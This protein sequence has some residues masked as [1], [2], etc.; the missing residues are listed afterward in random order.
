LADLIEAGGRVYAE[1]LFRAAAESGRVKQVDGDLSDFMESL[2]SDRAALGSLLNPRLPQ[3]AKKRIVATLLR[4]ADPL[5][6]NAMLVLV[7]NGRLGLLHDISVAFAELAAEQERILDIEV[8]TA[9]PMDASQTDRLAE[10]IQTATGLQ[11][12]L[13]SKVDPNILGGLVLRARGVLLDASVRRELDEIHRALI[14][15][16][17]SVGSDA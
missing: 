14:T 17:L 3:E 13:E 12:R 15:T 1:A 5:V 4:D 6:R 2:A 7:D 9:V 11:A 16:P 8:T 10:R